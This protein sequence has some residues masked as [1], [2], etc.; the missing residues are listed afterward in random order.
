MCS[1][2]GED[3]PPRVGR[4]GELQGTL[5]FTDRGAS[6]RAFEAATKRP[7]TP[8]RALSAPQSQPVAELGED[9]GGPV[10]GLGEGVARLGEPRRLEREQVE[11]EH[12]H[13]GEREEGEQDCEGDHHAGILRAL[14]AL[15]RAAT[16]RENPG[17]CKWGS[18]GGVVGDLR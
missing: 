8:S 4:N 10:A 15:R 12:P 14:T 16:L 1:V 6:A 11:R 9:A 7:E 18:H 13:A 5:N 2:G 3:V 17:A